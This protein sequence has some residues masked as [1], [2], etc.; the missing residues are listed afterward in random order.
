MNHIADNQTWTDERVQALFAMPFSDL[1]YQAQTVHRENFAPNQV[2]KSRLVNIKTGGCPEDCKYCSQSIRYQTEVDAS[3]LMKIEDVIADAKAAKKEG[4]TRYCMGAAWR[5]PKPSHMESLCTM[6]SEVKS[7]GLETCMTLGLLNRDQAVRLKQAGLDFYNHNIDTS[8]EYYDQIITT[9][10]F[11][12][13]LQ[14]ISYVRE[15]GMKVCCGGILGMGESQQDR[16]RMLITLANMK[17]P[18]ESVPINMLVPIP[19]TPLAEAQRVEPIEFVRTVAVARIMLPMSV[20]RL[21][22]GRR[23]MSEE[24][25]ALCFF[26]GA[27]SIFVGDRLLTTDNVEYDHDEA[28]F[29]KL[30]LEDMVSTA[31]SSADQVDQYVQETA[32]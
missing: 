10:T 2:Q 27:N 18:P 25:Q 14:T 1:L 4:A 20:L 29:T 8:P 28:L 23:S 21:S 15:A 17:H 3:K 24:L 6:V 16:G 11:D 22:A 13:R 9:R 19:G 30:G 12:D 5:G 32:S 31:N 26:A 7:L